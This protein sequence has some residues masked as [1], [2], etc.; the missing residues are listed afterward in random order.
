MSAVEVGGGH[1]QAE[2]EQK[3]PAAVLP[4]VSGIVGR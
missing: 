1:P 2:S 4:L 3:V